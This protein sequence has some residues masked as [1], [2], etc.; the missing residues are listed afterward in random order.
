MTLPAVGHEQ[1][2][3]C[4][5][6]R[7]EIPDAAVQ[8]GI[9]EAVKNDFEEPP[10]HTA[11]EQNTMAMKHAP[12]P[13]GS[14]GR[15]TKAPIPQGGGG[16]S[17]AP[18]LK[19]AII[20]RKVG[21]SGVVVLNGEVRESTAQFSDIIIACSVSGKKYDWGMKFDS[22]NYRRLFERFGSNFAK[23]KGKVKVAVDEYAGKQYVKV[24]D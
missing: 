19:A 10:W 13:S 12:E 17:F 16:A 6:C 8:R 15:M 18:F 21:A 22:G 5:V 2:C 14:S 20:G 24:T 7:G 4:A 1:F 9:Q 3:F 11:E 23:W